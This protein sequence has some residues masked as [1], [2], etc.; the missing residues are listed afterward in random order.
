MKEEMI[1]KIIDYCKGNLLGKSFFEN[2]TPALALA[3]AR[4]IL[5]LFPIKPFLAEPCNV[6]LNRALVQ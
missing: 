3:L 2:S 1:K 6:A 4:N 5:I